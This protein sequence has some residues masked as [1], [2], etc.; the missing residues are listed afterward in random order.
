MTT[1]GKH[2]D[3]DWEALV[4]QQKRSG[5]NMKAFCKE[6]QLPYQTFKSHKNTLQKQVKGF[7]EAKAEPDIITLFVN[8]NEIKIDSSVNDIT[9]NRII[10]ALISI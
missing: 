6:H 7:I 9:L 8:G 3:Y 1:M 10:K 5:M 4:E 2:Y